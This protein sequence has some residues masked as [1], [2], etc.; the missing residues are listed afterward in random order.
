VPN[1]RPDTFINTPPAPSP[2]STVN[3]R[4]VTFTYASNRDYVTFECSLDG[5]DF[6]DCPSQGQTYTDLSDGQHQFEVRAR[7][8]GNNEDLSPATRT[9]TIDATAPT[10]PAI[11]G[12]ADNSFDTDGSVTLSGTAEPDSIVKVFDGTTAKGTTPPVD[13]SGSWSMTLSAVGEGSHTYTAKATDA[14]GNTSGS[15]GPITV[16]VDTTKPTVIGTTPLN[17]ATNVARGTNLTATFSEKMSTVNMTTF[18]L[19]KVNADGTQ[20]QITDVVVSLSSD[21]HVAKL[22]PFGTTTTLLA[23]NTKYKGVITTETKDLSRNSLAQQKS[24]TFTTKP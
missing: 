8:A 22:D 18:K 3:S 24:W 10:T 7:D 19:F 15:G 2:G 16:K 5:S 21:R 6:S 4:D 13:S 11:T 17:R 20:T 1:Y 9:W 14:A 23:R 12:P